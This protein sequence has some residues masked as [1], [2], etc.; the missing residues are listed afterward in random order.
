MLFLYDYICAIAV[1]AVLSTFAWLHG[2]V[3][4][5]LLM[6]TIPWLYA[7]MF[8]VMICFPQR[9]HGE[10]TYDARERAWRTMRRD[11]LVWITLAIVTLLLIPFVNKALCPVCDYPLIAFE[12]QSQAAPIAWLPSC[13]NRMDHLN[14]VLWFVPS[15]TAMVAVKHSLLKRGKRMLV[16]LLVWNGLALSIVGILQS[17]TGARG[18]L[19]SE[20][21]NVWGAHPYFFSTFGYP[22]MAGDY[23]TTLFA[24]AV[25]MWRWRV[26]RAVEEKRPKEQESQTKSAHKIFWSK[27]L[28][29]VPALF[30]FYSALM[31]LSRAAILLCGTL[32][33][34]FYAHT[35]A[36]FLA[37]MHRAKRVKAI[38]G[39]FFAFV[40]LATVILVF[41]SEDVQAKI[42][43]AKSEDAEA[44]KKSEM[45]FADRFKK[46]VDRITLV[47]TLDRASGQGQYH[48]RVAF[49]VWK[50]NILFGSGGWSYKHLSAVKMTDEEY[51]HLQREG[52]ANVHND[53]LQFFVEHGLVVGLL[54]IWA[55]VMLVV[56]VFRAWRMILD[57]V[58]FLKPKEQPPR[59]VAIFALPAPVFCVLLAAIATIL[60][61]LGDCPLRSPAV[62]SLFFASLA[63]M[64]G[65]I[66]KMKES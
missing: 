62:M 64:D 26:D 41:Q 31:T 35:V 10:T 63:A 40:I 28:M 60:H 32:A 2:G 57:S 30:F 12:G 15:L 61:S 65:F 50:D 36:S 39:N 47:D 24:L 16:E 53:F 52:G 4:P 37:K 14:V 56:P 22:N 34:A 54:L 18:P 66:P 58:R 38:V 51:R 48:T 49:E 27:H 6:P 29:L 20:V 43:R 25:A 19:W 17:V 11:P 42:R 3:R 21:K 7:I 45:T 44:S 23:F 33:I 46:E 8:E 13:V 5:D 1:A 9:H 55:T 59:P